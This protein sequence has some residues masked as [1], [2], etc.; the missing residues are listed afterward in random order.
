[1]WLVVTGKGEKKVVVS[2]DVLSFSMLLS[3]AVSFFYAAIIR[4]GSSEEKDG[5]RELLLGSQKEK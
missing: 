5:E 2:T 4:S 1:M 3:D